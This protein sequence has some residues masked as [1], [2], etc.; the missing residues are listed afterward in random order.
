MNASESYL[1]RHIREGNAERP[2]LRTSSETLSYGELHRHVRIAATELALRGV[3]RGDRVLILHDDAPPAVAFL[4]AAMRIGAVPAPIPPQLSDE[5]LTQICEDCQPALTVVDARNRGRTAGLA[6]PEASIAELAT[7]QLDWQAR[8]PSSEDEPAIAATERDEDALIQY[9]S[10][11]TGAPKGVVHLHQ[12]L[13]ALPAGFGRHLNLRPA[14]LCFSAAKLSFGYGLGNSV[15]FPM[16]AGA[17]AFLRSQPSDPVALLQ[18]IE[19]HHPTV[20]FAGPTLYD[21]ITAINVSECA[22]NLTSVRLYVSAGDALP[23]RVFTTWQERFAYQIM[24]GLGSTECLHIFMASTPGEAAAGQLGR[25][26]PPYEARLVDEDGEVLPPSS[27]GALQVRGPAVFDRY[28]RRPDETAA[29]ITDGWVRTG[30]ILEE[31][32]QGTYRYVGR[33]DDI[34]KVREMKVSPVEI[35]HILQSHPA[36]AEA[37]VVGQPDARDLTCVCA[38]VRLA[39]GHEPSGEL[40]RTLRARV[41]GSLSPHKAPKI[42]RFVESLPRTTTGKLSRRQLRSESPP[43]PA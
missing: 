16:A 36:V 30:D 34:F 43:G 39:D 11:S 25:V 33:S 6:A 20:V 14:D 13:F 4:F 19:A 29:T 3:T 32:P 42:F 10:G 23:P 37:A 40:E 2:A 24:D 26:I 1:D 38:Y 22:Y 21:A 28:W 31:G 35:E 17:A 41:R 9:T 8:A 7:D 18:T 12:G 15:L 5:E 27:T